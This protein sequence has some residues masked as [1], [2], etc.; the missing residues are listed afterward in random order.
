MQENHDD[1]QLMKKSAD[2]LFEVFSRLFFEMGITKADLDAAFD[3]TY[4]NMKY[5]Q[6]ALILL[7]LLKESRERLR[8]LGKDELDK[9]SVSDRELER[10]EKVSDFLHENLFHVFHEILDFSLEDLQAMTYDCQLLSARDVSCILL[11]C[12]KDVQIRFC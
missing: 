9:Y 7:V 2:F 3:D 10:I 4:Q 5:R 12:L 11:L 1:P 6:R 8:S